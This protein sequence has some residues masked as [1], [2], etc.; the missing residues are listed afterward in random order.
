MD[1]KTIQETLI[2]KY[3]DGAD[4]VA[5]EVWQDCPCTAAKVLVQIEPDGIWHWSYG[6]AKVNWP[7]DWDADY[8]RDLAIRKAIAKL[9]KR[10]SESE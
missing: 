10:L 8:G 6:F 4:E 7:D 5:Y 9:A 2:S 3:L 1:K